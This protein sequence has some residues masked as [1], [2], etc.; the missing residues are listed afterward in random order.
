MQRS[1]FTCSNNER[2]RARQ[3][4]FAPSFEMHIQAYMAFSKQT[5]RL[6]Y[7]AHSICLHWIFFWST[8]RRGPHHDQGSYQVQISR[9]IMKVRRSTFKIQNM[10]TRKAT[11]N[12][13]STRT[14]RRPTHI[15]KK[16]C[17]TKCA[18]M[19]DCSSTMLSAKNTTTT[20][21]YAKN[22]TTTSVCQ[23]CNNYQQ[24]K[25]HRFKYLNLIDYGGAY[26]HEHLHRA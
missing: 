21:E 26:W 3:R 19:F 10:H 14:R 5:R 13:Q 17:A 22:A 12:T 23:E 6:F 1:L 20:S 24:L 18:P 16:H 9:T 25:R 15:T 8:Q 2:L 4:N 11:T 7:Q